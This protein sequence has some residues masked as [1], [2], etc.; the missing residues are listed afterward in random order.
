MKK[1]IEV[2]YKLI[3]QSSSTSSSSVYFAKHKIKN[4]Q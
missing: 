2:S 4:R 1:L 3:S